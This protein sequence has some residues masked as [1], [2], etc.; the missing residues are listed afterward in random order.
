MK[1]I[2][3]RLFVEPIH[4]SGLWSLW[5]LMLKKAALEFGRALADLRALELTCEY[6]QRVAPEMRTD[7]GLDQITGTILDN[8]RRAIIIGDLQE[9]FPE[10]ERFQAILNTPGQRAQVEG[11][12]A[13]AE[14][15]RLRL[16]DELENEF[17]FQVDRQEV[18]FYGQ[19]ELFGPQVAKKFKDA[20]YDI[21]HAGNCLALQQPTACVFH[22]MRAMEV[23][24][25]LL[26]HALSTRSA[27]KIRLGRF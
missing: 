12:K 9:V 27:R 10:L 26:A 2:S 20:A 22:L 4:P 1:Q 3:P 6:A 7:P 8:V 15:L 19:K 14:H 18:R 21:E 25:R 17:Y 16:C 11:I 24:L 23:A 5:E 13:K